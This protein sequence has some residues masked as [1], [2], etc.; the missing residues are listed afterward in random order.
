M[1]VAEPEKGIDRIVEHLPGRTGPDGT[2]H[3]QQVPVAEGAAINA[4]HQEFA[5]RNIGASSRSDDFLAFA[6]ET[7][8]V[9]QHAPE[10]WFD[11]IALLGEYARQ[12]IARPFHALLV[13]AHA[14]R[15]F[16]GRRPHAKMAEQFDEIRIGALVEY[17]K[18]GIHRRGDALHRNVHRVGVTAEI[19][20]GFEKGDLKFLRQEPSHRQAGNSRSNHSYTRCLAH[21]SSL[22]FHKNC[23]ARAF[24]IGPEPSRRTIDY[25]TI[26]KTARTGPG[27]NH[28]RSSSKSK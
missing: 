2:A 16:T 17:Q 6:I 26:K 8:N 1:V 19:V 4:P 22:N 28:V 14:E 9:L 10:F 3:G 27:K 23:A 15:H 25:H 12:G 7:Q 13:Y 5:Q 21:R 18:P 20:A 24:L 11:Q